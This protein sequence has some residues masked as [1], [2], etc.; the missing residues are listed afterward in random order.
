MK[1]FIWK[2]N[3]F[4][5]KHQNDGKLEKKDRKKVKFVS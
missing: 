5:E 2:N 4:M 1:I 3:K